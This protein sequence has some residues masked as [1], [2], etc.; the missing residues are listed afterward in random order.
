MGFQKAGILNAWDSEYVGEI[1]KHMIKYEK[2]VKGKNNEFKEKMKGSEVQVRDE[3]GNSK[4]KVIKVEF[5]SEIEEKESNYVEKSS[6]EDDM[7]LGDFLDLIYKVKSSA[8]NVNNPYSRVY[9]TRRAKTTVEGTENRSLSEQ[10][11][12]LDVQSSDK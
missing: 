5:D 1:K 10:F 4:E 11:K 12:L 6:E 7:D 2:E 3:K 9:V 8:I